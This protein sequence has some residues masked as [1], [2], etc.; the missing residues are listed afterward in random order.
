M[1]RQSALDFNRRM[2]V[3]EDNAA[4]AY[5]SELSTTRDPAARERLGRNIARSK[6]QAEFHQ[7]EVARLGGEG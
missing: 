2:A 3:L 6:A 4:A 5:A 1:A 7:Q